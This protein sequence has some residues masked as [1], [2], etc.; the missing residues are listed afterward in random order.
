[1]PTGQDGPQMTLQNIID[2]AIPRNARKII[3]REL[4]CTPRQA[5]RIVEGRVPSRFRA[6]LIRMLENA[7]DRNERELRRLREEIRLDEYATTRQARKGVAARD[8]GQGG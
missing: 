3:A 2:T 7:I 8:M 1:M 6:A 5:R 4:D